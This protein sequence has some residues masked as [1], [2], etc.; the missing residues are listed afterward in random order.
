VLTLVAEHGLVRGKR[1][2]IDAS[3]IEGQCPH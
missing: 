1:L 3:T 2:G